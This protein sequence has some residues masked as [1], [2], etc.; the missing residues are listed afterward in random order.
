MLKFFKQWSRNM[1]L[2]I[3]YQIKSVRTRL[4]PRLLKLK[5]NILEFLKVAVLL[6]AESVIIV[7]TAFTVLSI[8][9]FI[10]HVIYEIYIWYTGQKSAPELIDYLPTELSK[11][12]R[13]LF[14][15]FDEWLEI[16]GTPFVMFW[17]LVEVVFNTLRTTCL[18]ILSC[19]L[20][21]RDLIW[22]WW[23]SR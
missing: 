8:F 9:L 23:Q 4:T 7:L 16:F 15:L 11:T 6:Y 3:T 2:K 19:L 5:C 1:Q 17:N 18:Y 12:Y 21:L 10:G 14:T 22:D 13:E 20:A